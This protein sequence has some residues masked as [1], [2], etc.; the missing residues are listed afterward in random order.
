MWVAVKFFR[1]VVG[2]SEL[3]DGG[4]G[5]LYVAVRFLW[6]LVGSG[7]CFEGFRDDFGLL[8]VCLGGSKLE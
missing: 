6:V 2:G 5:S 1:L 7:E 3:C 4:G 8:G